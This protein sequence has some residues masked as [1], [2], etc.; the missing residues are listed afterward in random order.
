MQP[1]FFFMT[2]HELNVKKNLIIILPLGPLLTQDAT[3]YILAFLSKILPTQKFK[4]RLSIWKFILYR[5][6]D[7]VHIVWRILYEPFNPNK[8]GNIGKI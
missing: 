6:Y 7:M 3:I 1:F 2:V 8:M 4:R 5:P